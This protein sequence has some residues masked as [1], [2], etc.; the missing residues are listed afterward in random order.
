MI[1]M[2][3]DSEVFDDDNHADNGDDIT[4]DDDERSPQHVLIN[5]CQNLVSE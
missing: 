4:H 3:I 1:T 5:H 2:N